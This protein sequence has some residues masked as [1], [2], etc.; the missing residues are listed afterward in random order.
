MNT[1]VM[2]L[3]VLEGAHLADLVAQFLEVLADAGDGAVQDDPAIARLVPDAY[4]EDPDAAAEFRRYT[5]SDLLQRRRADAD[6]VAHSLAHAGFAVDPEMLTDAES[7]EMRSLHLDGDAVSAWMRTLT[8]IRLVLATRLGISDD[9][10]DLRH[11][12]FGVYNW[13]GYRLEGLL[14]AIDS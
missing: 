5:E 2:E 10:E 9:A 6:L 3:S 14:D 12:R 8:A 11:P 7:A 4:R 1:L 13:L